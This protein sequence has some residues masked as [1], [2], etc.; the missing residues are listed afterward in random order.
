MKTTRPLKFYHSLPKIDLHRHLEGCVRLSTLRHI[1]HIHNF[2]IKGTDYLRPLVQIQQDEPFTFENFLSKFTTLREFYRSKEG[3]TRITAETIEDAALDNIRYL[4]LRFT[5]AALSRAEEFPL[6]E[7]MDWVIHTVHETQKKYGVITHLIASVNRHESLE[8][9]EKVISLA[10]DRQGNGVVG[11]DLAGSEANFPA[12]PFI[13]LFKEA[14]QAGLHTTIHAGEWG[15]PKNVREAIEDFEAERIGHG[16]RV[17]EDPA[18][19]ELARQQ[20]TVFEVCVTSNYQSGVIPMRK[21]HP[22]PAMLSHGLNATLN[23][24]DPSISQITLSHE[25]QF[26]CEKLGISLSTIA[27]RILASAQAAFLPDHERNSMLD[28]LTTELQPYLPHI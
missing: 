18:V 14:R 2:D 20:G 7:V 12:T 22:F 27:A 11:V 26:V 1:G 15:G 25:Y 4:E 28:F 16:V 10:V 5:P 8:L 9:A 17:M 21:Q 24:D 13:S 23:T 19:V 3:I 6:D